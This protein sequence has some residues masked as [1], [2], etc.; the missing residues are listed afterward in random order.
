MTWF[1][2]LA[3]L[4]ACN[5][6]ATDNA[7]LADNVGT[8][9]APCSENEISF[10]ATKHNVM[11]AFRPCGNNHFGH[12]TWSPDGRL[13]YFQLGMGH[14]IMNGDSPQKDTRVVPTPSPLSSAAW[15]SSSRLAVFVGPAPDAA[16]GAANRLALYDTDQSS[17]FYL[18]APKQLSAFDNLQRDTTPHTLLFTANDASGETGVFRIDLADGTVHEP[19]SW[20]D[21]VETM[22][23][24]PSVD[25]LVIGADNRVTVFDAATGEP[26]G[27][28]TPAQ[29]GD[30][31]RGG[32]WLALEY[33]G[34][35]ISI[36]YQ[37][38]WDE[39][40]DAARAR[41]L[42]RAERFTDSLPDTMN[43]HVQPPTL[44][45]VD[46]DTGRRWRIDSVFGHDFEWYETTDY[47]ASFAFW[48][49]EG[50]QYK[51][52]VMLGNFR[53]RLTHADEGRDFM[54]IHPFG[55]PHER[56]TEPS[57]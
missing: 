13:L 27:T 30:L 51:R 23:F 18:Q 22:T 37:R 21:A 55:G 12:S 17:V 4:S 52:N 5:D 34:E 54:G 10:L 41:E 19:F 35:P 45:F 42:R 7:S 50:K 53:S 3:L 29:R 49:F 39:L 38:S 32:K 11:P 46:M 57:L 48:G 9:F 2:A 20:L 43:T 44:S 28:W 47:Y 33:L 56:P 36:F 1:A 31:H 40:S 6:A 24:A 25:R 8:A 15:V 14:H 16:D 26:Q